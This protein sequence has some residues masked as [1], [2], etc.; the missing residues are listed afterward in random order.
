MQRRLRAKQKKIRRDLDEEQDSAPL[1]SIPGNDRSSRCSRRKKK[2]E[3]KRRQDQLKQINFLLIIIAIQAVAAFW[4]MPCRGAVGLACLDPLVNPGEV[5]Q[6][7]HSIH[8]S[9][10][11]GDNATDEDLVSAECASCGVIQDNLIPKEEPCDN[12][13]KDARCGAQC[14]QCTAIPTAIVVEAV[15]NE[16]FRLR[17]I[18]RARF[19]STSMRFTVLQD[20]ETM[21]PTRTPAPDPNGHVVLLCQLP[22][23]ALPCC[24]K[25]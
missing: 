14:S 11:S 7:V 23:S 5:S 3:E 25:T 16:A 19:L 6:H 9:S 13:V 22:H 8:G 24:Q 1:P 15:E 20:P 18:S 2:K 17:C 4:R 12:E 21:P 10:G